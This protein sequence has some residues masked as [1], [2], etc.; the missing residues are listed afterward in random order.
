[1]DEDDGEVI[2]MSLPLVIY[3]P[4][5]LSLCQSLLI[6]NHVRCLLC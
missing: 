1:M 3:D 6:Y 4:V 5:P 2:A